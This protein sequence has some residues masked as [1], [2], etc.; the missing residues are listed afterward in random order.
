MKCT[1]FIVVMLLVLPSMGTEPPSVFTYDQAQLESEMRQI[2]ELERKVLENPGIT[3]A[4]M[5]VFYPRLTQGVQNTTDPHILLE[6]G[7]PM[8]VR[9][10]AAIVFSLFIAGCLIVMLTD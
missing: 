4:E 9:Y 3:Y 5:A 1:V 8:V 10:G 7:C 6:E 2:N